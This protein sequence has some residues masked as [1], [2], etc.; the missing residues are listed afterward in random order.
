MK[1]KLFNPVQGTVENRAFGSV[2]RGFRVARNI[3]KGLRDCLAL[4]V[5]VLFWGGSPPAT[6][7]QQVAPP[8]PLLLAPT[9]VLAPAAARAAAPLAGVVC[10]QFTGVDQ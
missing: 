9:Q 2:M 10:S 8:A 7:A 1:T 4:S 5:F 3:P 6:L